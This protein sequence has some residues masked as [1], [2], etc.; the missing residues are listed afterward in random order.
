M[1]AGY[2]YLTPNLQMIIKQF[3]EDEHKIKFKPKQNKTNNI[4]KKYKPKMRFT[5]D[6]V[7]EIAVDR[8]SVV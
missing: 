1:P 5:E 6:K 3:F 4:G 7:H 2:F 8:K